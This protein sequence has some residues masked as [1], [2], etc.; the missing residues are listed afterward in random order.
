M[1][2]RAQVPLP[3]RKIDTDCLTQLMQQS[4]LYFII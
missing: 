2:W 1:R 3:E 4:K